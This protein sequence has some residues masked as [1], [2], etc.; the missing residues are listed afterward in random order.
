MREKSGRD[1][2]FKSFKNKNAKVSSLNSRVSKFNKFNRDDDVKISHIYENNEDKRKSEFKIEYKNLIYFHYDKKNHIKFNC[3]NKNKL[4][5]YVIVITIKND[6][7]SQ[8]P[9]KRN[10]KNE[11]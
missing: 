9:Q 8:S 10:R 5:I 11:K 3:L 1:S 6:S 4:I 7:T 2:N